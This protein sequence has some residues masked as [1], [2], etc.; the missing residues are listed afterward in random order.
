MSPR[1]TRDRLLT[2]SGFSAI[3][4]LIG[5][6]VSG[7]STFGGMFELVPQLSG[8]ALIAVMVA[9]VIQLGIVVGSLGLKSAEQH[10]RIWL[11]IILTFVVVSST[12]SFLFY[13]RGF[14]EE[15]RQTE[16]ARARWEAV[17]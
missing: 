5:C 15:T 13:Y 2:L 14:S 1:R 8:G 7:F 10:R 12:T 16:L 17:R 3:A 6:A 9:T 4:A 11:A